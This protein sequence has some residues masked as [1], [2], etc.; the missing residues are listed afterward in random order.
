M[1]E[2]W[3]ESHKRGFKLDIRPTPQPLPCSS[4]AD[5]SFI[6]DPFGNIYKCWEQV[7][8]DEHIVGKM[9]PDGTMKKTSV[10]QDVLDRDPTEIPECRD[11]IYLPSC[12]GGCVCKAYWQNG[13]Y[14]ASGC[15]TENRLLPDKIRLYAEINENGFKPNYV[16]G[17]DGMKFK[18][19]ANK[20]EPKLD[21]CYVLV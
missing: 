19:I 12:A 8:L 10:Y 5:G 21:H 15:G 18:V 9:N 13:T 2:L 7:G 16:Y 14:H 20:I 4:V 3:R 11:H 1:P 6:V 17:L